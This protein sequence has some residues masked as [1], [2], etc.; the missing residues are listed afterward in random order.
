MVG[1]YSDLV[2]LSECLPPKGTFLAAHWLGWSPD[3]VL[4][5]DRV[6]RVLQ[7]IQISA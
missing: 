6:H 5:G 7:T 1:T 2:A 3:H 4:D